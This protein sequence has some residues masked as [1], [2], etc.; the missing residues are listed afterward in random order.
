MTHVERKTFDAVVRIIQPFFTET[1]WSGG[2]RSFANL[3]PLLGWEILDLWP[4]LRGDAQNFSPTFAEMLDLA[5]EEGTVDGYVIEFER[6]D[7]RV[8]L[9]AI[10]VRVDDMDDFLDLVVGTRPDTADWVDEDR[11]FLHLWWD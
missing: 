8:T 10:T 6:G 7:C 1:G 5:D 3:P 4:E 9:D 11:Q 2:L